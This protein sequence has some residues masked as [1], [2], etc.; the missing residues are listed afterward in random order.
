MVVSDP[1]TLQD[2]IENL[3]SSRFES[4]TIK[5]NL[6]AKDIAYL[7]SGEGRMTKVETLDLSDVEL[8]A[9]DEPY[10]QIRLGSAPGGGF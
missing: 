5:G 4:L 10:A 3:E 9:G 1:G 6:N 8:I 2:I 7:R